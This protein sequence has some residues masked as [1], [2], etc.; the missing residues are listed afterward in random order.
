M[1][2]RL[3]QVDCFRMNRRR[4]LAAAGAASLL[5]PARSLAQGM[6]GHTIRIV[7]ASGTGGSS[8]LTARLIAPRLA[9]ILGRPVVV[10]NRV[11]GGGVVGTEHVARGPKDGSV[12]LLANPGSMV[13]AVGLHRRLPYDPV[14]DFA[15]V[16]PI[17]LVPISFAVTAKDLNV[18]SAGELVAMLRAE[19]GKLSYGTNGVGSTSHIAMARFLN[20]T[21]TQ[22]VHVPYRSGGATMA[23]V[24]A[25]EVQM[26]METPSTL[27][28]PHA[29]GQ[30]R[31]LFNATDER[32]PLM[33]DVPTAAEAGFPEFKAYS[34][35]GLA[36]PAG[37]PVTIVQQM[38]AAVAR[39]LDDPAL[40]QR[41]EELALPPMRGYS[42]AAFGDYI[43]GE[44]ATWVP[45]VR[46]LGVTVD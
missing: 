27:A 44:I 39:A 46:S 41:Y 20:Q 8:D 5:R 6:P 30:L 34:W 24:L 3:N 45:I 10:E 35:F 4:L 42:P 22:A 21:G 31:C 33:P 9:E 28:A 18:R 2:C 17:V 38:N 37:T 7:V 29:A 23:A 36:A 25:G 40:R 26:C 32:T 16:A 15:P 14:A 1:S 12:F 11:G 13:A 19:P 43:R